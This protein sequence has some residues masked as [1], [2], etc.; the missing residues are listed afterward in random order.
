MK[1]SLRCPSSRNATASFTRRLPAHRRSRPP[2]RSRSHK[3]LVTDRTGKARRA[4][5]H[6]GL[7][8]VKPYSLLAP[9]GVPA[10]RE[11]RRYRKARSDNERPRAS[12]GSVTRCVPCA[13][14]DR[15][16]STGASLARLL[17]ARGTSRRN[18]PATTQTPSRAAATEWQARQRR[19]RQSIRSR[20]TVP[21]A[22]LESLTAEERGCDRRGGDQGSRAT[23][24]RRQLAL[25]L[26]ARLASS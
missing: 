10:R 2:S 3:G 11:R 22:G 23:V 25:A 19:A 14:R 5:R 13:G 7:G 8:A 17:W 18:A 6:G 20:P 26:Q 4:A 1:N 24:S 12:C 21:C 15:D 9:G 16:G